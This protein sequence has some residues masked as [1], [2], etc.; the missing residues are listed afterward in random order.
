MVVC[1]GFLSL[2]TAFLMVPAMAGGSSSSPSS[3]RRIWGWKTKDA[4][5]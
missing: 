4:A 3:I 5:V 1:K 2:S